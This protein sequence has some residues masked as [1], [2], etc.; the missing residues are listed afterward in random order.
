[1]GKTE[2]VKVKVTEQHIRMGEREN[3]HCCPLALAI[4][5]ALFIEASKLWPDGVFVSDM[6]VQFGRLRAPHT[7][8][9]EAFVRR[10]DQGKPVKPF[11]TVLEFS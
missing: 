11:T 3:G 1:M 9:V 5:D 2:R 6:S 7:R 4:K 8:K 10:F